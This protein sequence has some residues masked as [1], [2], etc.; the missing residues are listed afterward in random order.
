MRF[1]AF[2]NSVSISGAE[3]ALGV[4]ILMAAA[5][6]YRTKDFSVFKKGFF[7]FYMMMIA[8]E[9]ISTFFSVN[10]GK[11]VN[12]LTSF[13]IISY[14]PVIYVLF[15][16]R[17]R[18]VYMMYVYAGGII[19]ALCGFYEFFI[20]GLE[21]ADGFFSHALTYGNIMALLSITASGVMIFGCSENRREMYVNIA[22]LVLCIPALMFSG[23]RG[24][25]LA[26]FISLMLM[27]IYRFRIKGLAVSILLVAVFAGIV[28]SV[29]T[30]E[31]RFLKAFGNIHVTDS[32]IGTRIV[33]WEAA[34]RAIM[35]RPWFGH[36]KGTFKSE[37]SKYID[38]PTSSR[39]HA[40]NSY[41]QY[42]FLHGF[43]G[44]FAML[45]F[46]GTLLYEIYRRM[47]GSGYI[48]IAMFV[49]IV[50][51]L[52]GLTEN[53]FSDSEVVLVCFSLVGM[54]LAPGRYGLRS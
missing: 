1:G 3:M 4:L 54:M 53:N 24:P 36:G 8:A 23:S 6:V 45:G 40:H 7:L 32:S 17:S 35:H 28:F 48:K 20:Q 42:T 52:E 30:L 12:S 44:L 43:V 19:A 2:A 38:V 5:K 21:R 37:I 46:I 47:S 26:Y 27:F 29:P 22:V 39:A 51:L 13:W 49:M 15:E 33:L 16:G 50:F 9:L 41:I 18:Y 25:I 34:S 10:P 14:L 31:K 11:S